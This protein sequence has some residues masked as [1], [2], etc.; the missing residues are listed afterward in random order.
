MITALIIA[1]VV[2]V[3][4]YFV[5]KKSPMVDENDNIIE[6][7]PKENSKP[8]EEIET[9]AENLSERLV[10]SR[11]DL[12]KRLESIKNPDADKPFAKISVPSVAELPVEEVSTKEAPAKPAKKRKPKAKAKPASEFPIEPAVEPTVEPTAEKPK[13]KRPYRK[14]NPKKGE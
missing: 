11:E 10:E 1:I 13:K 14:R 7:S 3:I 6:E 4:I 2:S 8:I 9:V 12:E 5:M